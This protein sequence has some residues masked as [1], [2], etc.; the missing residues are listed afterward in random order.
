RQLSAAGLEVV[1]TGSSTETDL[2][3]AVRSLAE[4]PASA[5]LGGRL[6]L[7]ELTCLVS[8]ATVVVCGDTGVGHLATATRTPSVLLFGTV[9][10]SSWGPPPR[11]LHTVI[12]S[13]GV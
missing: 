10:P 9:P 13:P 3:R 5:D 12:H 6:D 7:V 8:S 2:V 4:L 11:S 1:V